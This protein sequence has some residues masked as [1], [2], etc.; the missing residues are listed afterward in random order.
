MG[1]VPTTV[2]SQTDEGSKPAG[3]DNTDT[4]ETA[5]QRK[6]FRLWGTLALL[7]G[8]AI[9]SALIAYHNVSTIAQTV[10]HIGWGLGIILAIQFTSYA[11]NGFAW[12]MLFRSGEARL[13]RTLLVL[14]WIRESI[15]YLLPSALL[16]GDVVAVRQLTVKGQD[17]NTASAGVVVDKTLEASGLFFFALTGIFTLLA[18]GRKNTGIAHSAIL[19]AAAILVVLM[20]FLAAQRWGLLKFIDKAVLKLAGRCGTPELGNMSIHD[21]VWTIYSDFR[22]IIPATFF[23]TLAWMPGTFQVWVALRYMGYDVGWPHAFV[24]ESLSQVACA[25]AFVMPASLG[26]QEAAYMT[27]AGFFGVPPSA[28]L[29][30]SLVYRL[31]DV[32]F[33]IPGLLV[34]QWLEGRRLW[35]FWKGG[36]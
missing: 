8:I 28:G 10:W 12:R 33:G 7:A 20:I 18:L 31:R 27:M 3:P 9:S 6:A 21:T 34:W 23:H 14:R 16:G 35:T 30:L 24:I 29:A 11:L 26:A 4:C 19:A 13:T 5:P 25:A 17:M 1:E 22:R 32:L 36:K 2:T 15:N